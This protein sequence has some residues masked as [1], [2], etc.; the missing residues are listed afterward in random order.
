[1]T[2]VLG[3]VLARGGSKGVP[4]KNLRLL[5]GQPLIAYTAD[6]ARAARRLARIVVST[7]DDEIAEVARQWGLEVPF[8]RPSELAQDDTPSLPVVQHAIACLE[9]RGDT[10]D[11]VCQ[12]QPTSPLRAPGEIDSCID[13]LEVQSA[14]CVM[15]VARVPDEYNP[16][17]VY[18]RDADGVLRLSTGAPAPLPRRQVLPPAYHRDGS[19]Y[20]TRRDVI[21]QGN[22]LYGSRVLGVVMDGAGRVNI[23]RPED[24][25]HAEALLQ[26]R[27][28]LRL[29]SSAD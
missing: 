15:T 21:V 22:S 18:F 14:D 9:A 16:H 23:D 17:W 6:A 20:V 4:R 26:G 3:L 8:L 5:S 11:A 12:L 2:R 29:M 28:A 25:E 24:L 7:D 10:F 1:M 27:P 13:L 19:V